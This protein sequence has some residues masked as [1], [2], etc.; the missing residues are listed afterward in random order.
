MGLDAAVDVV[1]QAPQQPSTQV[2]VISVHLSSCHK[3]HLE[4]DTTLDILLNGLLLS[5]S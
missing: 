4:V 1:R 3:L 2:R 5:E